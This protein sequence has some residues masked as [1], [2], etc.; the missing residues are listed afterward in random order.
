M[1]TSVL[2]TLITLQYTSHELLHAKQGLNKYDDVKEVRAAAG[3]S[4]M[5]Q[6]DTRADSGAIKFTAILVSEMYDIPYS[7]AIELLCK[8]SFEIGLQAFPVSPGAVHKF[9][10]AGGLYVMWKKSTIVDSPL[11]PGTAHYVHISDDRSLLKI[12]A[13]EGWNAYVDEPLYLSR[14]ATKILSDA[15]ETGNMKGFIQMLGNVYA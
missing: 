10:R 13:I 3:N 12:E 2:K 8:L 11:P 6:M 4:A 9:E 5:A 7:K 15:I 1:E 14:A